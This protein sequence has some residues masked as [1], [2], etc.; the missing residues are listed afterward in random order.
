ME[1]AGTRLDGQPW[2]FS[3]V[4][5]D[6]SERILAAV[7]V[8]HGESRNSPRPVSRP[9]ELRCVRT[10]ADRPL[11]KRLSRTV[12]APRLEGPGSELQTRSL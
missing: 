1:S 2:H 9:K 8:L 5:A 7:Y 12:P 6:S 3:T 4:R 10:E 11:R